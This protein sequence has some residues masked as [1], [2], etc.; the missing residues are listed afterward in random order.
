MSEKNQKELAKRYC[1]LH[2]HNAVRGWAHGIFCHS[3]L[4]RTIGSSHI[5]LQKSESDRVG[6]ASC[7]IYIAVG[8]EQW[9]DRVRMEM[10]H[11]HCGL[12]STT[13]L[14]KGYC[15]MWW[16]VIWRRSVLMEGY[17]P[18]DSVSIEV[19]MCCLKH[20]A[21]C[22]SACCALR[23]TV[24][25]RCDSVALDVGVRCS[26]VIFVCDAWRSRPDMLSGGCC[27]M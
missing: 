12:S 21:T 14:L 24:L 11:Y 25:F 3:F 6:R 5:C 8:R 18:C 17:F 2:L 16:Y 22:D 7:H 27:Y 19:P 9:G 10:P 26:N 13:V 23:S 4:N 15:S 1:G 20:T